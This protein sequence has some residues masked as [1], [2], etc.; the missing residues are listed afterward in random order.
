MATEKPFGQHDDHWKIVGRIVPETTGQHSKR[1]GVMVTEIPDVTQH[2]KCCQP[3]S[4]KT[5]GVSWSS[6]TS[7]LHQLL[8]GSAQHR[9]ARPTRLCQRFLGHFSA[10]LVRKSFVNFPFCLMEFSISQ[11]LTPNSS[12]RPSRERIPAGNPLI[13]SK[14][15]VFHLRPQKIEWGHDLVG[16]PKKQIVRR[17]SQASRNLLCSLGYPAG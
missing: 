17:K 14:D 1:G 8:L 6:P 16:C 5:T 4:P 7:R 11:L 15:P 3:L 9:V 10:C 12:T 2:P 13:I